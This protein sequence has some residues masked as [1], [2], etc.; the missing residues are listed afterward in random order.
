MDTS[1]CND[2]KCIQM[3]EKEIQEKLIAYVDVII[4]S[5]LSQLKFNTT[6]E[7]V[8]LSQVSPSLYKVKINNIEYSAKCLNGVTYQVNDVV[9]IL[10]RNN[11]FSEKIILWKV[12]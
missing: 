6:I 1:F 4:T 8:I 2:R 10:I 12:R 5:Y 3:T 7:G 11:N 9:D